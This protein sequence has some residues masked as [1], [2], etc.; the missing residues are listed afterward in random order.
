ML[1]P[2][3]GKPLS[4]GKPASPLSPNDKHKTV[5]KSQ[6]FLFLTW[7][8]IGE[9]LPARLALFSFEPNLDKIIKIKSHFWITTIY[10]DDGVKLIRNIKNNLTHNIC[11]SKTSWSFFTD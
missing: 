9:S 7:E 11:T 3:P 5:K 1:N 10:F 8:S 4:P 6:S 2:I